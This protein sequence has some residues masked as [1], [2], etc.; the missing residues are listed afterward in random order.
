VTEE[1]ERIAKRSAEE[2]GRLP[3]LLLHDV[4]W[5]H[6]RRD[7]YFD[8]EQIPAER[9]QPIAEQPGLF[10]GVEGTRHGGLPYRRS[11]AREGGPGNGVMTAI[12]DF[13]AG[14]DDVALA[15]FPLFFGLGIA[16]P[17][18]APYAAELAGVLAPF[19]RNP[20]LERLEAN[21]V[22]HLAASHLNYV[23]AHEAEQ[24]LGRLEDLARRLLESRAFAA[25][26]G[27]TRLRERGEPVF[28]RDE[29]RRLLNHD[30]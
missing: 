18:Q 20:L 2:G 19:D 7:D 11:A 29:I 10:P 23:R 25:A 17:R 26:E 8:P 24:R 28:S 4:G 14:R 6:G 13:V 9:R 15:V 27:W 30:E 16:Y 21:R 1:L 5:P 22:L 12:E 3:L